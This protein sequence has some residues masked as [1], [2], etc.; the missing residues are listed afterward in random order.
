M[1]TG[2]PRFVEGFATIDNV[3]SIAFDVAGLGDGHPA[4]TCSRC[5]RPLL[6]VEG[7]AVCE[8]SAYITLC[9]QCC[10]KAGSSVS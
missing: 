8:Q 6:V 10:I 3:S 7:L 5:G 1:L 9:T 2:N 4:N